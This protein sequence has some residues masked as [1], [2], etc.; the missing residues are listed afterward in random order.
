[1]I[2][3]FNREYKARSVGT[4][5]VGVRAR[6]HDVFKLA[7]ID[8]IASIDEKRDVEAMA[9][10]SSIATEV[11]R[12]LDPRREGGFVRPFLN[13][14]IDGGGV[15]TGVH[16]P[17][18]DALVDPNLPGGSITNY[19]NPFHP[20]ETSTTIAYKLSDD[21]NVTLRIYTL[22][23]SFVLRKDFARGTQGGVAGLNEFEWN[24]RNGKGE[25]VSS[26]GYI[27]VVEAE[28][29]GETLHVMRRRVAVGIL[30]DSICSMKRFGE[31]KGKSVAKSTFPGAQR[32]AREKMSSWYR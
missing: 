29:H 26:G 30:T 17:N 16:D 14:G 10:K 2:K 24:G 5:I 11:G 19:P 1:M 3:L 12:I 21:A 28:G 25:Y 4:T 31:I 32:A 7:R 9:L 6:K 27:V 8:D 15:Y 22:S 18:S 23:G 13:E 20:G